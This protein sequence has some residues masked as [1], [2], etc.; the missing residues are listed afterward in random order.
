[1]QL[2]PPGRPLDLRS[3]PGEEVPGSRTIYQLLLVRYPCRDIPS[4][5]PLQ[6][7]FLEVALLVVVGGLGSLAE[8]LLA[9]EDLVFQAVACH[10]AR[11]LPVSKEQ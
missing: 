7:E 3:P 5:R 4:L 6:E 2:H 9:R 1:M 8:E 11:V 10:A